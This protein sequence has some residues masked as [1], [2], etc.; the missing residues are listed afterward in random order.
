V[1]ERLLEDFL[2]KCYLCESPVTL[3]SMQVD[4]L[5]GR[6]PPEFDW[7][8]LFPSC[9]CNQHRP[10]DFPVLLDPAAGHRVEARLQQW[11]DGSTE[12]MFAASDAADQ[13]ASNS[14]R[15][16]Q[17]VHGRHHAHGCDLRAAISKQ[18]NLVYGAVLDYKAAIH[19]PGTPPAEV[20]RLKATLCARLSQHAPFTMLVRSV[21]VG[22]F[23][24]AEWA[25]LI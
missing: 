6:V 13:A 18:L 12:P 24:A 11:L 19:E 22:R 10:R 1:R 8:N 17:A 21:V 20:E 2:G 16:L 14:A 15:E 23:S 3:G 9:K 25:S 4:H 5:R 7:S